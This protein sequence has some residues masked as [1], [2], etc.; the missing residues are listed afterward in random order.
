MNTLEALKAKLDG[1]DVETKAPPL[2]WHDATL[3]EICHRY[4]CEENNTPNI[5]YREWRLKPEIVMEQRRVW[6]DKYGQMFVDMKPH[7]ANVGFSFQDGELV[8][9]EMIK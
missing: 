4:V 6:R 2:A 3:V 7:H 5:T 8:N 9:V 1:K